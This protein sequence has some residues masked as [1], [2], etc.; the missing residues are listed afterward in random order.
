MN[1]VVLGID[2]AKNV[3]ALH[4]GWGAAIFEGKKSVSMVITG[5]R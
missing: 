2:L 4:G 1:I 5:Q 3:L